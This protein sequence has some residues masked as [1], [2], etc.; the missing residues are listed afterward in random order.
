MRGDG[1]THHE[2]LELKGIPCASELI[3]PDTARTTTHAA[4]KNTNM[5]YS[6]PHQ[7]RRTPDFS[8]PLVSSVFVPILIPHLSF[9]TIIAE[10][11][12]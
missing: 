6:K 2:K 8:Y 9:S 7:A 12:V 4:G 11:K 3:I 5:R 1:G 10:H